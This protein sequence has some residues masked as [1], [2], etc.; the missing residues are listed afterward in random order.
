MTAE[1]YRELKKKLFEGSPSTTMNLIE[2]DS[3]ALLISQTANFWYEKYTASYED[4]PDDVIPASPLQVGLGIESRPLWV[5]RAIPLDDVT[6]MQWRAKYVMRSDLVPIN[7]YLDVVNATTIQ[8]YVRLDM[9][10]ANLLS[11]INLLA[12][13]TDTL[14][15]ISKI[16]LAWDKLSVAIGESYYG[17]SDDKLYG[18]LSKE[19]ESHYNLKEKYATVDDY[20]E[21]NMPPDLITVYPIPNGI[22]KAGKVGSPRSPR[23]PRTTNLK[24]YTLRDVLQ[25]QNYFQDYKRPIYP[26]TSDSALYV[27]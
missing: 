16:T 24:A 17:S 1:W 25:L 15:P 26:L 2:H 20:V 7:L 21:A 6:N 11:D 4:L 8:M 14:L 5:K 10:I 9:T 12:G 22:T 19:Y 18:L 27:S 13:F 3:D 23:S